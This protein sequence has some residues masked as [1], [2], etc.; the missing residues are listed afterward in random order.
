M[1]TAVLFTI[2]N[3]WKQLKSPATDGTD[4]PNV[5]YTYNGILFILK[6]GKKSCLILQHG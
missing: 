2:A 5:I 3:R 1:S 6:K 4:K